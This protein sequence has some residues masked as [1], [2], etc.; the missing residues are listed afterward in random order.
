MTT[1]AA[2]GSQSFS[3]M[4]IASTYTQ[5][6][7]DRPQPLLRIRGV[8]R[9]GPRRPSPARW[10]GSTPP[11]GR[12]GRGSARTAAPRSAPGTPALAPCPPAPAGCTPS[13]PKR[14]CAITDPPALGHAVHLVG[15][16]VVPGQR[17]PRGPRPALPAG[18]PARRRRPARCS[19][20][21]AHRLRRHG[22]P[23]M[24]SRSAVLAHL[25]AQRAAAAQQL[26]DL[27]LARPSHSM[28]GQPELQAQLAL[29]AELLVDVPR[30]AQT[31]RCVASGHGAA[32]RRS[33]TARWSPVPSAA[34][35]W[36]A[37]GAY[38]IDDRDVLHPAGPADVLDRM[39]RPS[40]RP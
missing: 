1:L 36:W 19:L 29:P 28:A 31:L 16:H 24:R 30:R 25:L 15:L 9:P 14:I 6:R 37:S 39:P 17:G 20:T 34:S 5:P 10:P 32:A 40:P 33:A 26:V 8:R 13:A 12:P 11:R 3:A 27:D 23:P 21:H 7:E 4:P 35:R 22:I 2:R 38:G 18:C